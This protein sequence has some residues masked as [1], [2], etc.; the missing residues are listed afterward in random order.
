MK[1]IF[2]SRL[3]KSLPSSRQNHIKAAISNPINAELV[4]QL[5]EYLDDDYQEI[6]N[7]EVR[8]QKQEKDAKRD[9]ADELDNDEGTESSDSSGSASRLPH[10]PSSGRLADKFNSLFEEDEDPSGGAEPSGVDSFDTD[11]DVDDSIDG[12]DDN[13]EES[14]DI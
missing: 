6:V 5:K 9:E 2:A 14:P 12:P 1:R 11:V 13:V 8:R 4:S 7:N 10:K 3:Y